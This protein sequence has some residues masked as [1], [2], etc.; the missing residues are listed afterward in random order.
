ML[1]QDVTSLLAAVR[2][3]DTNAAERLIPVV[4]DELRRLAGRYMRNEKLDHT[5]QA[6]ALVHEA[7]LKLV[8]KTQINYE[9]RTHFFAVAAQLMRRILVDHARTKQAEKRGGG[10]KLPL[11]EVV[12]PG[13][14]R[15]VDI[16]ALDDALKTLAEVDVQQSRIIELRFFAGLSIE[17]TA[18]ALGISPATVKRDWTMAKAWLYQELRQVT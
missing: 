12:L 14:Q 1:N 7:Y 15:E 11:N 13:I 6:T 8:D 17:E 9:S 16:V 3:G 5:L 4:Y 18:T 2:E 10:N